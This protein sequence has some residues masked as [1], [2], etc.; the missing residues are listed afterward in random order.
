[1]IFV[2]FDHLTH[3]A[4]GDFFGVGSYTGQVPYNEIPSVKMNDGSIVELRDVLDFRPT[5]ATEGL[6]FHTGTSNNINRLPKNN[7]LV[8]YD[9][10]HYLGQKAISFIN[11]DR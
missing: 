2:K 3:G 11:G 5:R 9:I 10:E 1:M 6:N 4:A 7:D 8:T